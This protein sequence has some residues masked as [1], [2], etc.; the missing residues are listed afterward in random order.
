LEPYLTPEQFEA[1]RRLDTCTVANAIETFNVRLRNEGFVGGS[2]VRCIFEELPPMLGFA[3]TGRIR[4]SSPPI[5]SSL[6]PPSPQKLTFADRTDWWDYVLSIPPPRVV[7]MQDVDQNP[8]IGA[9]VGDVHSAIC[10]GLGCVGYVTN[11]AVRDLEDVRRTGFH[12]F[13]GHVSLSHAYAHIVDFGE[14]VDIGGLRIRPGDLVHGDRYGVQ[15]IPMR[16]A[17]Q[18]PAV[19]ARLDEKER[20]IIEYCRSAQFTLEGLR[21][22]VR[23]IEAEIVCDPASASGKAFDDHHRK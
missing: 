16:I 4:S 9:F 8:G 11:G 22:F 13:A 18:I 1:L 14:A 19:A 12:F 23:N 2:L 6:P 10:Q 3:V 21:A 17:S 20:R 5:A 7:V 15:T